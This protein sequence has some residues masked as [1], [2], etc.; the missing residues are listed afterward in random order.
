MITLT[1]SIEW[2]M[3]HRVPNHNN[4]C[5]FPHGHRYKLEVTLSGVVNQDEGNSSE[6]MIIDFGDVKGILMSEI[7]DVLDHGFMVASTDPLFQTACGLPEED[8]K[9][10]RMPFIPTAENIVVWCHETLKKAFHSSDIVVE[11]CRLYETPKSW[12]DSRI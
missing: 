8:L 5:R 6:G 1:R 2:D 11:M 9:V 4:Q 3:G 12:A 10:I 7:H